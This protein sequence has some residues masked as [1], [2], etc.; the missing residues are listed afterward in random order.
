[1]V[2][3]LSNDYPIKSEHS[4]ATHGLSMMMVVAGDVADCFHFF[5]AAAKNLNCNVIS[6][7]C[8]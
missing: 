2:T 6:K 3:S 7:Y 4:L 8:R 1:M 5:F